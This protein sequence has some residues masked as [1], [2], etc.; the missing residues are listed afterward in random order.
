MFDGRFGSVPPGANPFRG[1][2]QNFFYS[3]KVPLAKTRTGLK[4]TTTSQTLPQMIGAMNGTV[5]PATTRQ[6]DY[7]R[8]H[9]FNPAHPLNKAEAVELIRRVFAHPGAVPLEEHGPR[10]FHDRVVGA[11]RAADQACVSELTD[12]Q[13]A[14]EAAIASREEFWMDTCRD[15]SE[16]PHGSAQAWE[17]Y[18]TH[19]CLFCSPNRAQVQAVLAALDAGVPDWDAE[20]PELFYETL[21]LNFPELQRRA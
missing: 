3:S 16:L 11:R 8:A 4:F 17:L 5:E 18:R 10:Y 9:G 7:L 12:C 1:W 14:V 20:H 6:L 15:M 13:H 2:F 21:R 19:G